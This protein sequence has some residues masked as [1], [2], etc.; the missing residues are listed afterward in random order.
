M[1][2]DP[3]SPLSN[4]VITHPNIKV[5][6]LIFGGR[7]GVA[8]GPA[9]PLEYKQKRGLSCLAI[10]CTRGCLPG[11]FWCGYQLQEDMSLRAKQSII[12]IYY[13][14]AR[15]HTTTPKPTRRVKW[16]AQIPVNITCNGH[17]LPVNTQFSRVCKNTISNSEKTAKSNRATNKAQPRDC[18]RLLQAGKQG[19]LTA[20]WKQL[21]S[22][23]RRPRRQRHRRT[24]Q[25]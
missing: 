11:C 13:Y 20:A 17:F 16:F 24:P 22:Y 23:G 10:P 4:H 8:V 2:K 7:G 19:R 21:F 1:H 9:P 14:T 5:M 18:R 3:Q 15:G 12:I 6:Q 25:S